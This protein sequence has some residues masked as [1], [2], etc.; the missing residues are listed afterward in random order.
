MS[1]YTC[2]NSQQGHVAVQPTRAWGQGCHELANHLVRLRIKLPERW[3][4]GDKAAETGQERRTGGLEARFMHSIALD[5]TG[6]DPV[7]R[8]EPATSCRLRPG[9]IHWRRTIH[10]TISGE[11]V[12]LCDIKQ[13]LQPDCCLW[14][15]SH[16]W[17]C[18]FGNRPIFDAEHASALSRQKLEAAVRDTGGRKGTP[19]QLMSCA[20]GLL[21]S[22]VSGEDSED[23]R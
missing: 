4:E 10:M 7:E 5:T 1:K 17:A 13:W 3:Q 11:A 12:Q 15:G 2:S 14:V 19:R 22:V 16:F 18:A 21:G 20:G 23:S 8:D 6:P 9:C